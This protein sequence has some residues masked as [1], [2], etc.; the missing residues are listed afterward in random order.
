MNGGSTGGAVRSEPRTIR[1]FFKLSA[2]EGLLDDAALGLSP[3]EQPQKGPFLARP[4]G[5]WPELEPRITTEKLPAVRDQL[6]KA[7]APAET[8][9]V[10]VGFSRVPR[11]SRLL[12]RLPLAEVEDEIELDGDV[13]RRLVANDRAEIRVAICLAADRPDAGPGL[14]HRKGQW[15]AAKTFTIGRSPERDLFPMERR[16]EEGWELAGYPRS[17]LFAVERYGSILEGGDEQERLASLVLHASVYDRLVGRPD[18]AAE[19]VKRTLLAEVGFAL[20]DAFRDE[21]LES[22]AEDIPAGSVLAGL[23]RKLE[24]ARAGKWDLGRLKRALGE[25]PS[26]AQKLR[27]AF[28]VLA[29]TVDAAARIP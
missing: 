27:A 15:I 7:L 8:E 16:D 22:D 20:L 13:V 4:E 6:C 19:A 11:E 17:T 12:R 10:V 2:I 21:I 29:G 18:P 26:E 28:Q 1:P 3:G 9:L 14:P 24:R 25:D 5:G 23:V